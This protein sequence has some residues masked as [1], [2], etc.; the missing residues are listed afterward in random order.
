MFKHV[1]VLLDQTIKGLNIKPDG[2]YLDATLGGAGHSSE[3]LKRLDTGLLIGFDQD[4][5]ALEASDKR[6]SSIS[7]NYKL[8]NENFAQ[9]GPILAK[10]NIEL[11]GIL[12]DIGVSSHQIDTAQRGFSYMEDGKLDMRMDQRSDFSAYD[13]VNTYS[14]EDLADIFWRLGE[15][16][17]SKRIAE[18]I[19]EA[20]TKGKIETTGDLVKII[21]AAVPVGARTGGHPAKRVFQAIRI[22]VNRELKV[23]EKAIPEL[24]G[25]LNK[26]GRFCIISF[27]SLEDRIVK[28]AFKYE[29]L[30]CICPPELPVCMCDKKRRLK[31]ITRKP[32]EASNKEKEE[33]SRAR[34]AK[35]RIA[36]RV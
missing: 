12:M 24:T 7:S 30:T 17:W 16:K 15:E 13:L 6:L 23:L 8:Y 27:H 5:N 26:K 22:E 3:I 25:L 19:I 14:E 4:I 32:I 11:D 36:E 35:L 29:S 9:A 21:K 10:E 20:R 1:P 33:N 34:S 18:F 28:E 2:T 31:L